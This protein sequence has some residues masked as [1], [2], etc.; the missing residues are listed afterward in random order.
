MTNS[1][2]LAFVALAVSVSA[3]GKDT[4]SGEAAPALQTQTHLLEAV[5]ADTPYL[6]SAVEPAPL[7]EI[8][9]W[10]RTL[11][12]AAMPTP[13]EFEALFADPDLKPRKRRM[14]ALLQELTG[15]FTPAGLEELGFSATPR[16]A[17]YGIGVLPAMRLDVQDPAKVRDFLSRWAT[18]AGVS[19]E[20]REFA[21]QTYWSYPSLRGNRSIVVAFVGDQLV[22]GVAPREAEPVFVAELFN[23]TPARSLD[24]SAVA[25]DGA[26][27]GLAP[28]S[29]GWIDLPRLAEALLR[30]EPGAHTELWKTLRIAKRDISETCRTETFGL[31]RNVPR[32]AFGSQDWSPSSVSMRMAVRVDDALPSKLDLTRTGAPLVGTP[33]T[34]GAIGYAGFSFDLAAMTAAVRER[35][36]QVVAQPFACEWYEPLNRAARVVGSPAFAPPGALGKVT[37]GTMLVR[38]LRVEDREDRARPAV[39]ADALLALATSQPTDV[40]DFLK[41]MHPATSQMEIEPD[42][43][44]RDLPADLAARVEAPAVIAHPN[45][46]TITTGLAARELVATSYVSASPAP[47]FFVWYDGLRIME[48]FGLDDGE[49]AVRNAVRGQSRFELDPSPAGFELRATFVRETADE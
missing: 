30:P 5:P 44:F 6:V 10:L 1:K 9:P 26:A 36:A 13:E 48:K 35:A 20:Q 29:I 34:D 2:A 45:A 11:D 40:F 7:A 42:G 33:A 27:A 41:V 8:L 19:G 15:H 23:D 37:G 25:A 17:L 14:L 31:A 49:L 39:T 43:L 32:I 24:P 21:G 47:Y 22:A 16:F 4:P 3:C 18:R 12:D 38:D 46:L 28:Y